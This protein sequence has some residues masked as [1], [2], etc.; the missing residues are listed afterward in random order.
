MKNA[1]VVYLA[2]NQINLNPGFRVVEGG[3]FKV[4]K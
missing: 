1:E 2:G 4:S 3:Y